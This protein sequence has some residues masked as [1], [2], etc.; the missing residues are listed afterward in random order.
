MKF[1]EYISENFPKTMLMQSFVKGVSVSFV[2][3]K[4]NTRF[5]V[6]WEDVLA[7]RYKPRTGMGGR[8]SLCP[9]CTADAALSG[10]RNPAFKGPDYFQSRLDEVL[11]LGLPCTRRPNAPGWWN[12]LF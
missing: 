8:R 1:K 12:M 11:G 10:E 2:C 4:H 6:S 7:Q 9:T 5:D 3:K